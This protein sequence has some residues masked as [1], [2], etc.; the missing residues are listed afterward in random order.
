LKKPCFISAAAFYLCFATAFASSQETGLLS[1]VIKN[2]TGEVFLST[3]FDVK[4]F[5]K[6]REKEETKHGKI[7][8]APSSR[9]R[10]GLGESEWVS[11]GT[12][13]WQYDK[14]PS[15]QV[16]IRQLASCDPS[17]LHPACF[18]NT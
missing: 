8:V 17:Q 6:I 9:F 2:Y 10:I 5:W 11:D 16:I 14:S 18:R 1:R 3:S 4:I 13:M 12:T 7:V 15:P